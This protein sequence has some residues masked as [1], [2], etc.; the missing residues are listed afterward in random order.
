MRER[1]TDKLLKGLKPPATGQIDIWDKI[2]PGFGIRVSMGGRKSFIVGTRINGKYRRITLSPPYDG[3]TLADARK[4]AQQVLA[5]AQAGIGPDQRRRREEANTFGAVATAFMRDYAHSHRSKDQMQRRINNDLADWQDRQIAEIK[6]A[7]VKEIIRLKARSAPISANRLAALISKIFAWALKEELIEASPA[8]LIDR[9]GKETERERA[10][11]VDEIRIVWG[12]FGKMRYPFG[13]LFKMLLLTG[14][15]RGEVGGMK[16]SEITADGWRL[17]G[18]RAKKGK[19]HLVPLSSLARE[20]L[21]DVPR[22]GEFVFR[23]H[24]DA[25]PQSWG[26]AATKVRSLCGPMEEWRIHDLRRTFATQLRAIGV[27]RL[28]VSKLLNHA[29]AGTTKIYDRYTA[30]PEQAAAM[31]RWANRLREI[32]SGSSAVNVVQLRG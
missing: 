32:V 31:E 4:K 5:D 24:W 18:E 6:R 15:R 12:A 28:V 17:P 22:L 10:L 13:P 1:L 30:D 20:I 25:P 2:T 14:Q 9:P 23:H 29:E 19:G 26:R 11:S 3:L 27:D 21:A 16:W 8:M 7:D